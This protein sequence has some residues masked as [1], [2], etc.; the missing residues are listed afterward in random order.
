MFTSQ[1]VI[2][3]AALCFTICRL[4]PLQRPIKCSRPVLATGS[5]SIRPRECLK[6]HVNMLVSPAEHRV[7]Y[8]MAIA[9]PAYRFPADKGSVVFVH[10]KVSISPSLPQRVS[11]G[12]PPEWLVPS[13]IGEGKL[14]DGS[15]VVSSFSHK[16]VIP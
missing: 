12:V 11:E 3:L 16:I 4:N 15:V 6:I 14:H 5:R 10:L 8:I 13:G 9:F 7:S 2:V 1:R